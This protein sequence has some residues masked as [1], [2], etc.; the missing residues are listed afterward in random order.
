[1]HYDPAKGYSSMKHLHVYLITDRF[2]SNLPAYYYYPVVVEFFLKLR[3]QEP[4]SE[5]LV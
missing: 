1:M 4:N 2:I 5:A 3:T